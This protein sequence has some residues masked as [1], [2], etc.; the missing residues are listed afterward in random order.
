MLV[1]DWYFIFSLYPPRPAE[2]D[3]GFS[4]QEESMSIIVLDSQS[5]DDDKSLPEWCIKNPY[6]DSPVKAHREN[7][8]TGKLLKWVV[9]G[10]MKYEYEGKIS[11]FKV[12]WVR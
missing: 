2:P 11:Q 1:A 8:P 3:E 6:V 12:K 9:F 5:S 7:P 4:T 10:C